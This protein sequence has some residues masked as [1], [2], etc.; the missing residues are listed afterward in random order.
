MIGF[1]FDEEMDGAI[2]FDGE[3]FDRLLRFTLSITGR[4]IHRMATT[5]EL[6]AV[7]VIH[8]DGFA[9]SA[10]AVGTFSVSPFINRLVVYRLEFLS[11]EGAPC[12][13]EGRKYIDYRRPLRT[14]TTL[15][16]TL[17]DE[18]RRRARQ[19]DHVVSLS[20]RPH[21]ARRQLRTTPRRRARVSADD[22]ARFRRATSATALAFS[23][24]LLPGGDRFA[25][26]DEDTVRRLEEILDGYGPAAFKGYGLLLALLETVT[27]F[28]HA[29]RRFSRLQRE[30]ATKMLVDWSGTGGL[31]SALITVLAMPAKLAFFEDPKIYATLGGVWRSRESELDPRTADVETDRLPHRQRWESQIVESSD[32]DFDEVE[33][34]VVV[35]GTGAG[36][37]V[38]AKELAENGLAVLMVEAGP[39]LKRDDFNNPT[40][41]SFQRLYVGKGATAALGNTAIP[42]PFAQLVGGTTAINCGTCFRTPPWVLERWATELGNTDL[43]PENME[44]YFE[45]V[46]TVLQVADADPKYVG[47]VGEIIGR[48]C[49][50]LGYTHRPLRRNAPGCDG[51]GVCTTGCPTGAKRSTDVSYVPPG[52]GE[53]RSARDEHESRH[54]VVARRGS[55]GVDGDGQR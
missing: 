54:R 44:Q 10:P 11:D 2:T 29:G 1:G 7:G 55:R 21:D 15:Y 20:R 43:M 3:R 26:A 17:A 30:A 8:I 39:Y 38:V 47:A 48:G 27:R 40:V 33:C 46:E 14:W 13:F 24:A 12:R 23:E 25:A 37:A 42:I 49:D 50:K 45:R 31:R 18:Q 5:A 19:R 52:A 9:E 28:G 22:A 51:A 4:H 41:Q 32:F 35:V 16:A 36:G 34:D 6:S 53:R